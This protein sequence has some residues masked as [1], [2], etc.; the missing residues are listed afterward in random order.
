MQAIE[1]LDWLVVSDLFRQLP[2]GAPSGAMRI[3]DSM[4]AIALTTAQ[5]SQLPGSLKMVCA[6]E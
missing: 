3:G 2:R 4:R 1:P 5:A 6:A